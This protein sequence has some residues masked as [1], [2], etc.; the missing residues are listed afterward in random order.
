MLIKRSPRLPPDAKNGVKLTFN[1]FQILIWVGTI[2]TIFEYPL[3]NIL[4]STAV[5]ATAIGFASTTVASNIVGGFY[6]IITKPKQQT[7]DTVMIDG[8]EIGSGFPWV[9]W[10]VA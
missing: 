10:L 2:L 1:I 6:I 4:I 8:S 3:Q 9:I 7:Y 5:L